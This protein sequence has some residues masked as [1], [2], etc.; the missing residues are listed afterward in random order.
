MNLADVTDDLGK[1]V[2]A[3]RIRLN[4]SQIEAAEAIGISQRTLQYWEAG[5][6][7]PRPRHRRALERFLRSDWE[8]DSR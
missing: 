4:L 3:H 6:T 1:R 2:K 8:E 5:N 7:F